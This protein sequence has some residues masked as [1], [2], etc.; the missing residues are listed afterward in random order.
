MV[1]SDQGIGCQENSEQLSLILKN[2]TQHHKMS[3][4]S[5]WH[6]GKFIKLSY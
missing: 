3:H 6:L 2:V 5:E 4:L 1:K